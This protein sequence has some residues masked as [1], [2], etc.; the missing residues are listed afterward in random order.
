MPRNTGAGTAWS[1]GEDDRLCLAQRHPS[2]SS[3]TSW[4]PT[5]PRS[6]YSLQIK[7]LN[8]SAILDVE[9]IVKNLEVKLQS[10]DLEEILGFAGS[11]G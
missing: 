9:N 3:T 7:I 5:S 4:T 8:K 10:P 11:G 6:T 2:S 1:H